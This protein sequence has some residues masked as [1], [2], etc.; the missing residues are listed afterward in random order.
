MLLRPQKEAGKSVTSINKANVLN[1]SMVFWDEVFEE[2]SKEYPEIETYSYLVDAAAMHMITN[3]NR[4]EVVVTSNLFG[5]I[6]TDLGAALTGGIGHAAG[7]YPFMFEPVHGS[8]LDISGKGIANPLAAIW[9]A[10]QIFDY[11]GFGDIGNDILRIMQEM[12]VDKSVFTPDLGG[13]AKTVEVGNQF[14]ELLSVN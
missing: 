8:A 4:F 11:L 6:L 7:E 9:S 1:Y 5:D 3:P 14:V 10:S 2:I 13:N 12:M